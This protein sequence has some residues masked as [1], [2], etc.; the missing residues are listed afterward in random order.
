MKTLSSQDILSILPHRYPFL[1]I[2]R[3]LDYN[4]KTITAVKNFTINEPYV[5]GHFPGNHIM[6]GF[7]MV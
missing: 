6:P 1:M 3:V 7:M 2:D 4:A 5:Q